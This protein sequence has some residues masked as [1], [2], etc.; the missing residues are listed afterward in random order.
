MTHNE[1]KEEETTELLQQEEGE[2][3]MGV[4]DGQENDAV[5]GSGSRPDDKQQ[6]LAV[7]IPETAHKISQGLSLLSL[8]LIHSSY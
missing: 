5:V 3:N 4:V 7:D 2:I 8:L 6:H 1:S